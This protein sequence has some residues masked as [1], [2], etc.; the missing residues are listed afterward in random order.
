MT[1]L[2]PCSKCVSTNTQF[3]QSVETSTSVEV[4][5]KF[6]AF[7]WAE[8]LHARDVGNIQDSMTGF[9][10]RCAVDVAQAIREDHV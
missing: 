10:K 5:L 8:L 7:E 3:P 6:S 4:L 2:C 9:I 1:D